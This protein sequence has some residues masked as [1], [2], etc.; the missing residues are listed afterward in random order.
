[1]ECRELERAAQRAGRAAGGGAGGQ[2]GAAGAAGAHRPRH[3]PPPPRHRL[4]PHRLVRRL[5]NDTRS[6][7]PRQCFNPCHCHCAAFQ[8]IC[9]LLARFHSGVYLCVP[10]CSGMLGLRMLTNGR[11]TS[12][13]RVGLKAG[14]GN[15]CAHPVLDI[16]CVAVSEDCRE[17]SSL[18]AV[19]LTGHAVSAAGMDPSAGE[20]PASTSILH[21]LQLQLQIQSLR[22]F[23]WMNMLSLAD[24]RAVTWKYPAASGLVMWHVRVDAGAWSRAP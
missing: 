19:M 4:R 12:H 1:M 2:R 14:Y 15:M 7:P 9:C 6:S 5:M 20:P 23:I 10:P 8:C 18:C 13:C 17:E 21:I 24:A 22:I 3:A 16:C 11:E